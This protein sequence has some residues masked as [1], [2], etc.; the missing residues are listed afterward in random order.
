[1]GGSQ[2]PDR[3]PDYDEWK[4]FEQVKQYYPQ[5]RVYFGAAISEEIRMLHYN[6]IRVRPSDINL[7][8][9]LK[10]IKY[11]HVVLT[12]RYHGIIFSKMLE[13]KYENLVFNYK[14]LAEEKA[15]LAPTNSIYDIKHLKAL[16]KEDEA[17][18]PLD[19]LAG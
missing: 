3:V 17:I 12:G 18:A 14:N 10:I 1:M 9:L 19:R 6:H 11:S 16:L 2:H 4:S 8:Q 5:A 13:V 15:N 7:S